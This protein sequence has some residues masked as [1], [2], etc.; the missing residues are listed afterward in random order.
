[1]ISAGEPDDPRLSAVQ[2]GGF[3]RDF[4]C[5]KAGIAQSC[6]TNAEPPPLEGDLAQLLAKEE[7]V[8]GGMDI[9]HGVQQFGGLI[10]DRR[11]NRR[12]GMAVRRNRETGG[13][14]Q[15]PVSVDIPDIRS[16]G[17]LPKY[18]KARSEIGHI[19]IF[20]LRE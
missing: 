16:G 5:L 15:K 7:L 12:M 2:Q 13:E 19:A 4:D 18:R 17:F 8:L 10:D 9:S 3:D 20:V 14:I 1:M 6:F 11:T